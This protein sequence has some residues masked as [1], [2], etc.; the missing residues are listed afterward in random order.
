MELSPRHAMECEQNN[1]RAFESFIALKLV[2]DSRSEEVT[3]W[4]SDDLIQMAGS[5]V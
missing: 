3:A 1:K 4:Q 5:N 2:E